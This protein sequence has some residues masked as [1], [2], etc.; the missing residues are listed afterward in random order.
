MM[1]RYI[2]QLTLPEMDPIKQEALMQNTILVIGAGGLGSASLPYLAGAGVGHII[3]AD[4]DRVDISNLHRQII[5][6]A[7]E[8]GKNKAACAGD[9]L[10]ELNPEIHVHIAKERMDEKKTRELLATRSVDLIL[11]GS[12][13]FATKTMLN[14][15]SIETKTPLIT[16]SIT[17]YDGQIGTFE[18]YKPDS[19]C[20]RCLFPEF[21]P[22]A[23]DCND[24]GILGP[25]AG[26]VGAL[27]AHIALCRLLN[28]ETAHNHHHAFTRINLKTLS[29]NHL[30][31]EKDPACPHCNKAPQNEEQSKM[32]WGV[33]QDLL[34][35]PPLPENI[36]TK[37]KAGIAPA[38]KEEK[39]ESPLPQTHTISIYELGE[40]STVIIDVRQPEEVLADPVEHDLIT[41]APKNIPLPELSARLEELPKDKRIAFMCSKNMRSVQ[42]AQYVTLKGYKNICV[43]DRFSF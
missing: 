8:A 24:V 2:R 9:F 6:Q 27:Q 17:Q 22:D 30:S 39:P 31:L 42:A 10:R 5:Y 34:G 15:I 20:Y 29:M 3:I 35:S 12:D 26:I 19:A 38:I 23:N 28:I 36:K 4:N 41:Q 18:G 1:N 25:C 14:T 33:K 37:I 13:N 32:G 7:D 16:A 11:D 43:L 40:T 21:P